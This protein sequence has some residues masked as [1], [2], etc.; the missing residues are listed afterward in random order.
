ML[1]SWIAPAVSL[2]LII[3]GGAIAQN[4]PIQVT[5]VI[6]PPYPQT[7]EDALSLGENST[8]LLQNTDQ[9]NSYQVKLSV[10]LEGDNGIFFRTI[11]QA[12]PV[13][14]I[15]LGPG[16]TRNLSSQELEALYTN[17][18]ENDIEYQGFN[19]Q[20]LAQNPYLPEG[21]YTICVT[22]LD[23]NTSVPLST[24]QVSGCSPT[25][26]I[27]TISPPIITYPQTEAEIT[28]QTPQLLNINWTPVTYNSPMIRYE[29]RMVDITD[30]DINPYD[31]FI[32]NN[33]L[34]YEEDNLI[35]T[36]LLYD[37]SK[38]QLIQDHTYAIRV[39]AYLMDGTLNIQNGGWSDIV[40]FTY[41]DD[42]LVDGGTGGTGGDGPGD[43]DEEDE[44]D[45]GI[46]TSGGSDTTV[47]QEGTF[48]CNSNCNVDP[49]TLNP[50]LNTNISQ[51]E[52]VQ[53][54][55]FIMTLYN[56]TGVADVGFTGTGYIEATDFF[57]A[58]IRVEFQNIKVNTE[59][60]VFSGTASAVTREGSWL[61]ESW[62]TPDTDFDYNALNK[63][64]QEVYESINLEEFFLDRLDLIQTDYGISVPV[65]YGGDDYKVQIVSMDFTPE[66]ASFN[67]FV[68]VPMP[69]DRRGERFLSF[70]AT[71]VC[72]TPGG[73]GLG[74][75]PARL[76][77]L[78]Q[79]TFEPSE[80][81]ALTFFPD[82]DNQEG[83]FAELDCNGFYR[84]QIKGMARFSPD[85]LIAE[86]EQGEVAPNDTVVASFSAQFG[87]WDNWM[88]QLDFNT[89]PPGADPSSKQ[90]SGR[91]R[92]NQLAGYSFMVNDAVIDHSDTLNAEL[93][94][95]PPNYSGAA[96]ITWQGVYLREFNIRLPKWMGDRETDAERVMLDAE[97]LLFDATGLSAHIEGDEILAEN[98]GTIDGWDFTLDHFEV[99]FLQNQLQSGEFEGGLQIPVTDSLMDY[100]AQISFSNNLTQHNF[101]LSTN[102]E[103]EMPG[104]LAS[105]TLAPNSMVEVDVQGEDDVMIQAN[106][107]GDI[108]LPE[109]IG[110]IP[111]CNLEGISFQ[112]LTVRS[113]PEPKYLE[114]GAFGTDGAIGTP[115]I[116]GFS[117][118]LLGLAFQELAGQE[119]GLDL[120][121]GMNLGT[122]AVQVSGQTAFTL[123]SEF[124]PALE[125][126][127]FE[128]QSV[129]LD[130]FQASGDLPGV[131]VEAMVEFYD[132]EDFGHGFS[133]TFEAEFLEAASVQANAI[134]GTKPD[135]N[136]DIRYWLVDGMAAIKPGI[137][138]APPMA[139]HGFGGGVYYNIAPVFN[140]GFEEVKAETESMGEDAEESSGWD[141]PGFRDRYEV[142]DGALGLSASVVVG[143]QAEQV[144][145]ADATLSVTINT[146]TWGLQSVQF[147]GNGVMMATIDDR[148]QTPVIVDV[149][150]FYDHP[151]Q[152]FDAELTVDVEVP[153]GNS[154]VLT[155][156]G[157][158]AIH[159]SPDLW[160]FKFGWPSES[161][162]H[163]I[164]GTID[165][166]IIGASIDTYFMTGQQLP[167]PVLPDEIEEEFNFTPTIINNATQ[168][169]TGVA[170]GAH[171]YL[172]LADIDIVVAALTI[173]VWA[174]F[175]VIVMDY[176]NSLCN[177]S[178]DFGIR[179]WYTNG[180]GYILGELDFS[181]LGASLLT[182]ETGLILEG[183]FPNPSGVKGRVKLTIETF[184]KD[185]DINEPFS[186]GTICEM[187]PIT[188]PD[189][190]PVLVPSPV[191]DMDL[192]DHLV[193][194]TSMPSAELSIQPGV[195][196]ATNPY[197]E[198]HFTY[199][200]GQGGI[201]DERI[202]FDL[203][204]E[205]ERFD[206][207]YWIPVG[208]YE[209]EWDE[210]SLTYSM[211]LMDE[212]ADIPALLWPNT[213]YRL[214]TTM[215]AEVLNDDGAW[216]TMEYRTGE[217][218]GEPIEDYRVVTFTTE[219]AP[220]IIDPAHIDFSKPYD[221]Q[222]YVTQDDYSDA[223]MKFN[224]S[225]VN[226]FEEMEDAGYS[227]QAHFMPVDGPGQQHY[228]EIDYDNALRTNF[229]M[230]QL[231]N[232]TIYKVVF[233]AT[234]P[235]LPGDEGYN[236]D[237]FEDPLE[238]YDSGSGEF[239][240][241]DV[242][243]P[244]YDGLNLSQLSSGSG[245]NS[246]GGSGTGG[247]SGITS[248]LGGSWNMTTNDYSGYTFDPNET[249]YSGSLIDFG[250]IEGI[251][252]SGSS[253]EVIKQMYTWY[254]R[255]SK[256]NT[257]LDKINTFNISSALVE[258]IPTPQ[259]GE[260]AVNSF[261]NYY[262]IR[263]DLDGGERFDEFDVFGHPYLNVPFTWQAMDIFMDNPREGISEWGNDVHTYI[264]D[265]GGGSM[266][267]QS[268]GPLQGSAG[269]AA[270]FID[271]V[272]SSL[273]YIQRFDHRTEFNA[274]A[275]GLN[276][277]Y[278]C[279][280][281]PL[282]DSEV[283]I[284]TEGTGG[285]SN[286]YSVGTGYSGIGS[287][288]GGGS[289]ELSVYF[290]GDLMAKKSWEILTDFGGIL[291]YDFDY[292]HM[293]SEQFQFG[294][295]VL[296]NTGSNE[297]ADGENLFPPVMI[298]L[299]NTP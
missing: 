224:T 69:D 291:D 42:S 193:P 26:F 167:P 242:N 182:I 64:P 248:N 133:G 287:A 233:T 125:G 60:K 7:Y 145:N 278:A 104:F 186:V 211:M 237:I 179:K 121:L 236:S 254:F 96:D 13:A 126:N 129:D 246:S 48:D 109:Q 123:L 232:E 168:S 253:D 213:Q 194:T 81:V 12:T 139:F 105:V 216:Q 166:G 99:D 293:I 147:V 28:G 280:S 22:A 63:T 16:E 249:D 160:Y 120:G 176:S 62:K 117:V 198:L 239:T 296:E 80:N 217:D 231:E 142:S 152:T 184:L 174:G 173:D 15:V 31:A 238:D 252:G 277:N 45:T 279:I 299:P 247:Y 281:P 178:S 25:I 61:D 39:R 65:G 215:T 11:P 258:V 161:G 124:K 52:E 259:A 158:M 151:N 3:S 127:K 132:D 116:A 77:L 118:A 68:Q 165:Y 122:G 169:G 284:G 191:E 164:N 119:Y 66:G 84:A 289:E 148:D 276:M 107:H 187:E 53:M 18:S 6:P 91:F 190:E 220:D 235:P 172:N 38:P 153:R 227:F 27:T 188:T 288:I 85:M 37:G 44:D 201:Y 93:M 298:N 47:L 181:V 219:G 5:T 204:I 103:I 199:P 214:Q 140:P 102:E 189:G 75:D 135:G 144:F 130:A 156:G 78:N 240:M 73:P 283:G 74:G 177:G 146:N 43:P 261:S 87:G 171:M 40:T 292:P 108:D 55:Q 245:G 270:Q 286:F 8:L 112:D 223:W 92:H 131:S 269:D 95:F 138:F 14:P 100:T 263:L 110:Q 98:E 128:F 221:R 141:M 114:V 222:R 162:E 260:D 192:I 208:D 206:G 115:E 244:N 88:G 297:Q 23:Y 163:Y 106:L 255:T 209:S 157:T 196:F 154:P 205:W 272:Y 210:N 175:D 226:V 200:D 251:T 58:P 89:L 294:L 54:G 57:P 230:P 218:E 203:D 202:R 86:D 29:F 150:M 273:P 264:Y 229:E 183:G 82:E 228:F 19:A 290:K 212:E 136:E 35:S 32:S 50:I 34:F 275:T 56:F 76:A 36:T 262:R 49:A 180:M 267:G 20:E 266:D 225:Y 271:D 111:G 295:Q 21:N 2:F 243:F 97:N 257:M 137:T 268:P 195:V 285:G 10:E 67:A 159:V 94:T 274:S 282:S 101:S 30:L 256:Y 17:Y 134:F 41:N 207:D 51:G 59:N 143:L 250:E 1:K 9:S 185:I 4:Q 71:G 90:A 46:T 83:S 149:Q 70:G 197:E 24:P 113:R 72:L 79:A 170:F 155:G 234:G 265:S 241:E 33:F